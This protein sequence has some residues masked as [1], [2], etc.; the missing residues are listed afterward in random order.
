M[1]LMGYGDSIAYASVLAVRAY[2][3]DFPIVDHVSS[4]Q[5]N[6]QVLG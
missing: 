4:F 1:A 6:S 3:I 5:A 2:A